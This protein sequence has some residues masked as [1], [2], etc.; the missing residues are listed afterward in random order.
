MTLRHAPD[1]FTVMEER[2]K[3]AL[4]RLHSPPHVTT[5]PHHRGLDRNAH[6]RV[7]E[8]LHRVGGH[9]SQIRA[10][11]NGIARAFFVGEEVLRNPQDRLD[12]GVI[13]GN[14]IDTDDITGTT[15]LPEPALRA[16]CSQ[17]RRVC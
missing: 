5:G 14:A 9:G 8:L 3:R 6:G 1:H 4:S 13:H 17:A 2:A 15:I 7:E 16:M 11:G 10:S 12:L